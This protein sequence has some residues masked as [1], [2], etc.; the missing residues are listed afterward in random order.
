MSDENKIPTSAALPQMGFFD[1]KARIEAM[2][3]AVDVDPLAVGNPTFI[4]DF[5]QIASGPGAVVEDQGEWASEGGILNNGFPTGIVLQEQYNKAWRQATAWIRALGWHTSQLIGQ[6]VHDDGNSEKLW[7]Q[8]YEA[9]LVTEF[10]ISGDGPNNYT[11][12]N[13]YNLTWSAPPKSGTIITLWVL[14]SNTSPTCT[15]NFMGSGVYPILHENGTLPR[16]GDIAGPITLVY[17]GS[18]TVGN[19]FWYITAISM[20][21]LQPRLDEII[22]AAGA[23][24]TLTGAVTGTGISTINTALADLAPNPAGNYYGIT[25]NQKGLVTGGANR[26]VIFS[27]H[28]AG[29]GALGTNF[30]TILQ[31]VNINPGT[32][33]GLTAD[34]YGRITNAVNMNY[35]L[36]SSL[37]PNIKA[38]SF[39]TTV[40]IL[41]TP[42]V[43]NYTVPAGCTCLQAIL[44]G[45][46]GGT[47]GSINAVNGASAGGGGAGC[48]ITPVIPVSSGQVISYEIGGGGVAAPYGATGGNGGITT[49]AANWY[50]TGGLGGSYASIGQAGGADRGFWN[51][52]GMPGAPY[53]TSNIGSSGGIGGTAAGPYGGGG[54]SSGT[55]LA[56]N[57]SFPGGGA[58]GP[59][60]GGALPGYSGGGGVIF[61]LR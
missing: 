2:A 6:H 40:D 37:V 17:S 59:G 56:Q 54:G 46:G 39:G 15:L 22:A 11:T 14:Y 4:N 20:R 48:C 1:I 29:E 52:Q 51:L 42:G 19:S 3:K 36:N 38:N 47:S 60:N 50:A 61:I 55:G 5:Y 49:F 28:V 23:A 27:G 32:F 53:G 13:F 43:Y 9:L 26:T 58:G 7:R 45:G 25:V 16:V 18:D 33:Q 35:A 12:A 44:V 8:F 30:N 21:M 34:V 57:G 10:F 24:T 31:A 41:S